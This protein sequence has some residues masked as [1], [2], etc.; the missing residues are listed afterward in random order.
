[1]AAKSSLTTTSSGPIPTQPIWLD[2]AYSMSKARLVCRLSLSMGYHNKIPENVKLLAF[3][4]IQRS[5]RLAWAC[6]NGAFYVTA[7]HPGLT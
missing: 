5:S 3:R 2:T 4:D 7:N 1:M 6:A